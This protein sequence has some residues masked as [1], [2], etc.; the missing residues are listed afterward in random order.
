MVIENTTD[1]VLV[2]GIDGA[3]YDD[4]WLVIKDDHNLSFPSSAGLFEVIHNDTQNAK[5]SSVDGGSLENVALKA[6]KPSDELKVGGW[7]SL[8]SQL[9]DKFLAWFL[10]AI[11][12]W[13]IITILILVSV[14]FCQNL[15]QQ[16]RIAPLM[17]MED[18]VSSYNYSDYILSL[19]ERIVDLQHANDQYASRLSQLAM[20]STS[21]R[22]LAVSCDAEL[23]ETSRSHA[24]LEEVIKNSKRVV[25]Y[26]WEKKPMS[27]VVRPLSLPIYTS[28]NN[29][30]SFDAPLPEL[31]NLAVLTLELQTTESQYTHKSLIAMSS[32][33][34]TTV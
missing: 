33:A 34:L 12:I 1:L 29:S 5:V 27:S 26:A 7:T 14:V 15:N 17:D 30:S 24:A 9:V 16:Q 31:E 22:S 32:K 25:P 28:A 10:Y 19:V 18:N 11:E 20:E 4:E 13:K 8:A 21:W 6:N 23:K 3:A 2:N